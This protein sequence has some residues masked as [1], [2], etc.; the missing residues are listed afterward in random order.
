MKVGLKNAGR[1]DLGMA[2]TESTLQEMT[3]QWQTS[4]AGLPAHPIV[5][6]STIGV[7]LVSGWLN[8]PQSVREPTCW[9][10]GVVPG[11]HFSRPPRGPGVQRDW[12]FVPLECKRL[13]L[14]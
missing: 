13:S 10:L 4:G 6:A 1:T 12:T 2:D 7:I 9:M 3:S 8:M 14:G 5:M 11:P